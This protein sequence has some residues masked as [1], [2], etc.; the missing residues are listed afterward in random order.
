VVSTHS[1]YSCRRLGLTRSARNDEEG[2]EEFAEE[3]EDEDNRDIANPSYGERRKAQE[4]LSKW[5]SQVDSLRDCPMY[6][7]SL[8]T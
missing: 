5:E 1:E 3:D 6:C 7:S 2:R 4:G 8:Y